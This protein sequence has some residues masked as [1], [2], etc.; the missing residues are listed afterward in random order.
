MRKLASLV[1]FLSLLSY[2]SLACSPCGG[3]SNVTQNLNGSILEL[4]FTSN[5]GWQCCYTVEIEIVCASS[6]YTGIPNYFSPE[7]CINGGSGSSSTW[8]S[9]VPYPTTYI[10]VADFCPGTYKWRARET[11]CG[12]G[13][14]PEQTF[15][16]TGAS[17]MVVTA[18]AAENEIC[19]GESTQLTATAANGCNGPYSFNWTPTTGLTG[20]NTATPTATPTSTTTYTVTVT[21]PGSCASTQTQEVTITVN[22]LPT[23]SV[24]DNIAVCIGD[25]QPTVTFAGANGT[26]PYTINYT[27]NGTPQTPLVTSGPGN[28]ATVTAPTN[29]VGFFSYQLVDVTDAS[30]TTC[31]QNQNTYI[32]VTVWD[33]PVI[34]AGNDVEICEPNSTSPS[35]VALNAAGGVSYTWNNGVTQGV[36]FTPPSGITVYTVTGTDANGCSNTDDV[37]VFSYPLPTANAV[38]SP[39]LGNYPM[40][41]T[42]DNQSQLANT[43]NWNFGNGQILDITNTS[44]VSSTYNSEGTY[45]IT[46]LASNGLCYDIFTLEIVVL[47][48]MIVTPP[49]VFTPNGDG[50]NELYIVDVKNGARFE[51]KIYNRWGNYIDSI[52]GLNVGW[53][54]KTEGGKDVEEGVYYIKYK[55]YDYNDLEIEG[56]TY[57]HLIR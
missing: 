21:E 2:E 16:I 36:P 33:L 31:S 37:T 8:G 32:T 55:A 14:I 9:P 44:N 51:G 29:Q 17:P 25:D 42:F 22:P 6:N 24:T 57:F 40:T 20:A 12:L 3:L 50:S 45:T 41:V 4:N 7:L 5:A 18:I 13:W 28:T 53:D 19:N 49:N 1:F 48:P 52:E 54:G 26:G 10:N 27:I 11:S 30:S 46:L 43:Y 56:H 23:A 39:I 38:A 47:P 35:E 15:T 34:A